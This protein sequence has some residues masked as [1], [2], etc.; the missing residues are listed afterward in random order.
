MIL[1]VMDRAALPMILLICPFYTC[2]R[3]VF[4]LI[5]TPPKR[6]NLMPL[7]AISHSYRRSITKSIHIVSSG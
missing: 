5:E 6:F 3:I 7:S 2:M 1:L 4:R